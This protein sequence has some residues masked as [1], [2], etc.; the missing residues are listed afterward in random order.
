MIPQIDQY[1]SALAA[2]EGIRGCSLVES[3]SGLVVH[4]AGEVADVEPLSEAAV[5]FWRIHER[6]KGNFTALGRLNLAMLAFQDGWLA[7]TACPADPSL[8]LVAV[9]RA[10]SVDW[11]GWL[12]HARTAGPFGKVPVHA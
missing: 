11:N 1:L 4:S 3:G 9:T 2:F 6:L 5:E 10:Q 7:L 12:K 8:L